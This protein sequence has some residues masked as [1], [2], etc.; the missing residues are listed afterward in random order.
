MIVEAILLFITP[1][2]AS[3][4]PCVFALIDADIL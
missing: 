4:L 1:I 2:L 3:I